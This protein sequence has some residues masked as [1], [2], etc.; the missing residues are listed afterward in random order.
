MNDM[1]QLELE[2]P[3]VDYDSQS[4]FT[5]DEGNHFVQTA[6]YFQFSET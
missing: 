4:E 5:D 3:I 2:E 6:G 1:I